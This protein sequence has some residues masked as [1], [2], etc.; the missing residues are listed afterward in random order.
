MP[1]EDPGV[2]QAEV[3]HNSFFFFSWGSSFGRGTTN[4]K[5]GLW[6]WAG[7]ALGCR[8]VGG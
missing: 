4:R 8:E 1:S 2:S 7:L 3:W 6:S 5:V